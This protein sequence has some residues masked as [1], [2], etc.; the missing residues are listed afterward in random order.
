MQRII[1]FGAALGC[2]L[3]F[4]AQNAF[5]ANETSSRLLALSES[6]RN[7]AFA[8]ILDGSG[9]PCGSVRRA[10]FQGSA[11]GVDDWSVACTNGVDYSIGIDPGPRG[12]TKILTCKEMDALSKMLLQRGGGDLSKFK[13]SCWYKR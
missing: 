9:E 8:K 10:A 4:S 3:V 5:A 7:A 12:E 6:I 1:G 2:Y 11:G 13:P